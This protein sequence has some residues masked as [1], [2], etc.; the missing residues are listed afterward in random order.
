MIDQAKICRKALC[1]SPGPLDH[2]IW[3]HAPPSL[4]IHI[5]A[6]APAPKAAAE[7]VPVQGSIMATIFKKAK[8]L[9]ASYYPTVSAESVCSDDW[10]D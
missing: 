3:T 2:D 10:E 6:G 5:I 9:R 4:D 1:D 8:D 7:K